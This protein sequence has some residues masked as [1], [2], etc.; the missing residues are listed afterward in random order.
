M[1]HLL[2]FVVL[3]LGE[4]VGYLK[5]WLTQI[6]LFATLAVHFNYLSS[7][8]AGAVKTTLANLLT[9]IASDAAVA[10]WSFSATGKGL[11]LAGMSG[12]NIKI[13]GISF[14]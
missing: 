13:I 11:A 3:L 5:L 12:Q 4:K 14:F 1:S 8:L 2:L 10:F 6:F 9:F 7:A